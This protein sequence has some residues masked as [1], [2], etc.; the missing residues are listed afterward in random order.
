MSHSWKEDE[1]LLSIPVQ[2][3]EEIVAVPVNDLTDDLVD[4]II[5]T[6]AQEIAPLKIWLGFAV[7][8]Y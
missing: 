5:T 4:D 7:S 3:G 6:L 1:L 8:C 2:S